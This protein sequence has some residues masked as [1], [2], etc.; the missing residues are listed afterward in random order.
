MTNGDKQG[1]VYSINCSS[2]AIDYDCLA[3]TMLFCPTGGVVA[4]IGST[5]LDFPAAATGFQL[6]TYSKLL[7]APRETHLGEAFY[8]RDHRAD[9]CL[10]RPG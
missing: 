8:E 2:A 7:L 3:E 5:N 10:G 4:Y 6:T 9:G 1:I